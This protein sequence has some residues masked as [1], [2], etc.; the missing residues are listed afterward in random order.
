MLVRYSYLTTDEVFHGEYQ[1]DVADFKSFYQNMPLNI[2]WILV[3]FSEPKQGYRV[4]LWWRHFYRGRYYLGNH[5]E[6]IKK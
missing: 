2:R 3:K 4:W 5:W 6:P 1:C